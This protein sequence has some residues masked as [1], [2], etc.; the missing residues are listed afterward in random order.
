MGTSDEAEYDNG[1]KSA[2]ARRAALLQTSNYSKL[3][4]VVGTCIMVISI[5][6]A[7]M[8]VSLLEI[9]MR[10]RRLMILLSDGATGEDLWNVGQI[11][12]VFAWAPLLV[13][14]GYNAVYV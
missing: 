9:I 6:L 8:S 2:S 10:Q 14:M 4:R 11:G 12:A 3:E 13:D 1:D 7:G 5:T